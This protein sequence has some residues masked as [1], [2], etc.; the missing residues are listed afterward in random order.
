MS[1]TG[2]LRIVY[3]VDGDASVREG[4]SRLM[5]SAGLEPRPCASVEEFLVKV[6]G[7]HPACVLLDVPSAWKSEADVRTSLHAVAGR[8][9]VIALS[10]SDSSTARRRAR[11]LGAQHFFRKPVDAAALL[12]SIEWVALSDGR[13]APSP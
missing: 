13:N 4:L 1:K 7:N 12:D 2:P 3:V 5:D 11:E 6:D 8:L 9:P 10:S